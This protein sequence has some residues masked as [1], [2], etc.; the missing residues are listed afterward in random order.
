M[1]VSTQNTMGN[2]SSSSGDSSSG[3]DGCSVSYSG[4]NNVST[5]NGG[6]VSLGSSYERSDYSSSDSYDGA[7]A[8]T[9]SEA[10]MMG[11]RAAI[12]TYVEKNMG[13]SNNPMENNIGNHAVERVSAGVGG[14][15][16]AV[17]RKAFSD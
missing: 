13:S 1:G 17:A 2:E 11:A 7:T 9:Y 6:S 3:S 16:G 12:E 5:S 15:I 8:S 14:C 10:C 4:S